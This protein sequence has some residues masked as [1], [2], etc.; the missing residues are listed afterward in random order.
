MMPCCDHSIP[1]LTLTS[2][3]CQKKWYAFFLL[4]LA[5]SSTPRVVFTWLDSMQLFCP[6]PRAYVLGLKFMRHGFAWV[7]GLFFSVQWS[8]WWLVG[9]LL[10]FMCRIFFNDGIA[11]WLMISTSS[12]HGG[13]LP[14]DGRFRA[15]VS[16]M[17]KCQHQD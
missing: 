11:L 16:S 1:Q 14:G 2:R 12:T 17:L 8:H 15:S 7:Q 10:P 4:L 13:A 3:C 9:C 6:F 5:S